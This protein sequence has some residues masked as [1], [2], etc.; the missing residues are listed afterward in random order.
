M[1]KRRSQDTAEGVL[2]ASP[3]MAAKLAVNRTGRLTPAQR[4]TVMTAGIVALLALLCP[5]ALLV[6]IGALLLT[7]RL[8][9]ATTG[10]IAFTVLGVLFILVFGGLALTNARMFLPDAFGPHPVRAARGPLRIR[11]PQRD[12]PELPFSYIVGDYSFAPYVGPEDLPMRRDAPYL[13]YYAA[14]SRLFLSIAALDAPDADQWLPAED[15]PR[16]KDRG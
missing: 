6:Q 9:A 14:H 10:G 16:G 4:R 1:S 13:V 3:E 8:P 2:P 12:R 11:L 7:D 15:E 5:L